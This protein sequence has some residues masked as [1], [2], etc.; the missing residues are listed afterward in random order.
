[1]LFELV[2]AY[3]NFTMVDMVSYGKNS[4]GWVLAKLAHYTQEN[5]LK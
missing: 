1:M 3:Y 5:Y 4:D 2:D